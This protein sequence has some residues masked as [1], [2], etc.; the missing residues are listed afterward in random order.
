M[1]DTQVA[2]AKTLG[3]TQ[4]TI[5]NWLSGKSSPLTPALERI[6]ATYPALYEKII[7][8]ERRKA[9]KIPRKALEAI[10]N[11]SITDQEKILLI[12]KLLEEL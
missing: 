4:A 1:K 8:V 3:V 7:S 9:D 2:I 6:Q 5:S 11:Q 12:Q 10:L